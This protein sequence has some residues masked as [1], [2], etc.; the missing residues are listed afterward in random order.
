MSEAVKTSSLTGV[1]SPM[2]PVLVCALAIFLLSGMDAAMKTLV[3][4]VGVYNTVLWRGLLATAVAGAAWSAGSCSLPTIA[5]LRLH[6]LRAMVVGIVLISFFW[7]LGR[8]PLAEAVGLSF[9]AP[10]IALF[11]AALL[12]GERVR[13]EAIWASIAGIVGVAIIVSRQFGQASYSQDALLGTAAVL[14]STVFYGYN[15]ILARQQALVAKPVE[16]MF[17]QSLAVAIILG[18]AAP[19]LAVALPANLWL[20]LAGV[21]ALSLAG[22]FL[23]SWS[24]ARAEAQYLIPTEYSAFIWAIAF[25]WFF[26]DEAVT[27]TTLAGACLIV[28]GCL[29]AARANPKLAEPIEAAV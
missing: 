26:F 18:L 16:I 25:G 1:V 3:I 19:W 24:Y 15:L 22:Q 23:M 7:G 12:L 21:T 28:A 9:V 5:V 8:L 20:P 17:F 29:I 14:V 10:L 11:L 27:W 4:A 2:I 6:A 13:R